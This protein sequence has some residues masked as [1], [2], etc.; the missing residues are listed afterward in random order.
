[1]KKF[2][3]SAMGTEALATRVIEAETAEEAEEK[4]FDL[5]TAGKIEAFDYEV[6]YTTCEANEGEGEEHEV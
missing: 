2:R 4:Y 1:M 3:V 6:E 5:W